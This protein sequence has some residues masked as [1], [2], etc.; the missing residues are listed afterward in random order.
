MIFYHLIDFTAIKREIMS[1]LNK[2]SEANF[3]KIAKHLNE[4]IRDVSMNDDKKKS[5]VQALV[6]KLIIEN[7]NIQFDIFRILK[8][9]LNSLN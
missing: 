2:I 4:F 6:S 9:E 5:N 8:F 1:H 7:V 3:L